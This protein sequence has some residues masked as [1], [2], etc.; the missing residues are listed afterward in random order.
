MT[1]ALDEF[2]YTLD[3]RT[4]FLRPRHRDSSAPG[5]LHEAFVPENVQC[6]QDGVLVYAE[7]GCDV[8]CEREPLS[9][10]GLTFGNRSPNFGGNLV[11]QEKGV[12]SVDVDF[13]HG[14]SHSRSIQ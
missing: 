12:V 9:W 5:E 8:F 13:Q 4:L 3:D 11:V 14:S 6:P 1:S 7:H 10:P 2:S